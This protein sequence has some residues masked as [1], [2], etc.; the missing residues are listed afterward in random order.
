[1]RVNESEVVEALCEEIVDLGGDLFGVC[2]GSCTNGFDNDGSTGVDI[3]ENGFDLALKMAVP[4]RGVFCFEGEGANFY[5]VGSE[6]VVV[7]RLEAV[8]DG[9]VR[10]E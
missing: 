10:G 2:D 4:G 6:E 3:F 1:M 5:F 7:G 9:L 8:R